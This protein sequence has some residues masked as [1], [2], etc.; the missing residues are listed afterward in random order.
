M[1]E[2]D[3]ASRPLE[4]KKE[5]SVDVQLG[6]R[7]LTLAVAGLA[8]FG[9]VLFLLGRW[10]ERMR[11]S[12]AP[13]EVA[14]DDSSRSPAV[15]PDPGSAPKDLTFYETLGKKSTPGLQEAPKS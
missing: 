11:R 13:V 2:H 4:E 12:E 10:S 9:L 15:T 1:P 14:S 6:G 8:L 5:S 7:H 3:D